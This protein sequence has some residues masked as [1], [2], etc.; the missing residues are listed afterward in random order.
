M[1]TTFFNKLIVEILPG[2]RFFKIHRN[3]RYYS[4]LIDQEV[5]IPAGFICDFESVPLFRS[6]SHRA[7][8][9]HDYFCRKDS[10]PVVTKQIAADL[11]LE[12][13][14]A[15]DESLQEGWFKKWDRAIRRN[16]K[17]LVVRIAPGYFHKYNV[18]TSL[19]KMSG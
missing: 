6:S 19:K 15:R 13:Q 10:I 12:A 11:Y 3:F 4:E 5:V 14:K 7:G 1:K 17:T 18:M 16:I 2:S 9:I 8:A